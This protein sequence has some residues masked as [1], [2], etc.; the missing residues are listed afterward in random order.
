MLI[1][2]EGLDGVGKSTIVNGVVNYFSAKHM[3]TPSPI[4]KEVRSKCSEISVTAE[5]AL[6]DFCNILASEQLHHDNS[7]LVICDRYI[8]STEARRIALEC[9]DSPNLYSKLAKWSWHPSI[10][11]PTICIHLCL[12]EYERQQRVRNRGK[13]TLDER[14]LNSDPRYRSALLTAYSE[15]CDITIEL[16]SFNES[17]AI[18]YV[19]DCLEN[20]LPELSEMRIS[21]FENEEVSPDELHLF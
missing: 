21:K 17:Q 20:L 16:T 10:Y 2:F 14:K 18:S 11:K 15:L 9:T 5:E 1:V 12:E 8:I 6:F 19:I 13:M 7:N 4:L 3:R